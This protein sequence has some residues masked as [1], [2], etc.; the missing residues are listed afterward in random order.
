MIFDRS[1]QVGL[2]LP[3]ILAGMA[4]RR[5]APF[6]PRDSCEPLSHL[7]GKK[8]RA[9]IGIDQCL[10]R[11]G[12]FLHDLGQQG[13]R[14]MIYLGK[15]SRG[16]GFAQG[17]AA[18]LPWTGIPQGIKLGIHLLAGDRA[19]LHIHKGMRF[20]M[21]KTNTPAFGMN[22]NAVSISPWER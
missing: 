2:V 10:A 9:A 22:R 14:S 19:H 12:K 6:N 11:A 5:L 3:G 8:T 16:M 17:D 13:R 20:S 7:L 4:D 21:V 1:N 15:S 18:F